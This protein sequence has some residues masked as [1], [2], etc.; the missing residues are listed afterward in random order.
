MKSL[1]K[2]LNRSE[3]AGLTLRGRPQ[4]NVSAFSIAGGGEPKPAGGGWQDVYRDAVSKLNEKNSA[5][6]YYTNAFEGNKGRAL[7]STSRP[8]RSKQRKQKTTDKDEQAGKK[9]ATL[10]L[11]KVAAERE[12]KL[13][14]QKELREL[15]FATQSHTKQASPYVR[16]KKN[17]EMDPSIK[18]L[19]SISQEMASYEPGAVH[20]E[21]TQTIS[22]K[23]PSQNSADSSPVPRSSTIQ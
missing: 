6:K 5:V 8:Q 13:D 4:P 18:L 7:R 23:L 12:Q 15:Y 14:G 21:T 17:V 1:T 10:N 16:N 19:D 3:A 2:L 9:V 20:L 11:E 22:G